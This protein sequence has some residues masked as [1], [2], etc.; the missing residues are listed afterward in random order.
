ME[1]Y[2]HGYEQYEAQ[3]LSDQADI[4]TELLHLETRY[5]SGELVLEAG[6]G[7]G[8]QTIH[9]AKNSPAANFVSIDQ[10]EDSLQ[11]AKKNIKQMQ[12]SNVTFQQAN[13][14]D[15]PFMDNSFDHVFLCF[16]LEHLNNPLK[17][18]NNLKRILKPGGTI[19]II[20]GDH[21][22]FYCHPRSEAASKVVH[23]LV[24]VQAAMG[25]NALIG[26]ELYP[27]LNNTKFAHV[28]VIPR[29]VYVDDSKPEWVNGFSKNTFIA[30]VEG[31]KDH[32]LEQKLIS[33]S[34]WQKGIYDLYNATKPGGTFCYTFF[35]G[36]GVKPQIK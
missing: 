23:C 12:L 18:I 36:V 28:N 17:A 20:E 33:E 34:L 16:V 4:L 15:L 32:A 14:F 2:V 35:K 25:G 8:A 10:S 11:L 1:N 29:M 7:V 22:S 31:I 27:L 24:E 6:C 21:E 30:M 3:R 19:T 5:Q 26:R 9:L 13:I